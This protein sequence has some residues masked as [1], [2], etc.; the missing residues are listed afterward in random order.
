MFC[1]GYGDNEEPV[2]CED[3][4]YCASVTFGNPSAGLEQPTDFHS[5]IQVYPVPANDF[6]NIKFSDENEPDGT[7]WTI[8]S[9]EGKVMLEGT[10][11]EPLTTILL[12]AELPSGQY[13]LN[14][15]AGSKMR[16]VPFIKL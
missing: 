1:V 13:L 2:A 10:F 12:P 3:N 7:Q 9:T 16:N 4:D 5:T 15:K 6:I 11:D 8:L 14:L